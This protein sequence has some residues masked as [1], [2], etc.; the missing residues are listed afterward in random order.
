MI[1][2]MAVNVIQSAQHNS[3]ARI[4]A[5]VCIVA[6]TAFVAIAIAIVPAAGAALNVI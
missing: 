6:Q 1:G 3:V 2:V 5:N 4:A